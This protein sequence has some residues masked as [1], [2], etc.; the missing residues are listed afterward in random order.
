MRALHI[1]LLNNFF[2]TCCWQ[3]TQQGGIVMSDILKQSLGY[4]PEKLY[5]SP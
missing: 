4:R 5:L 3:V 1:L 2:M